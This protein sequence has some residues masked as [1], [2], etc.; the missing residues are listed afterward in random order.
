MSRENKT[1]QIP[2]LLVGLVLGALG[3]TLVYSRPWPSLRKQPK[4]EAPVAQTQPAVARTKIPPRLFYYQEDAVCFEDDYAPGMQAFVK[5]DNKIP[6]CTELQ[7]RSSTKTLASFFLPDSV[8]EHSDFYVIAVDRDGNISEAKH[9]YVVDRVVVDSLPPEK[10][11]HST[12]NKCDER[13]DI[14]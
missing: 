4:E 7:R 8:K 1:T 10:N 3:A 14:N 5:Y 11:K 12:S 9:L 13:K 2:G 6:S